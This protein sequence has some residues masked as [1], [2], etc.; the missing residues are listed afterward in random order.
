MT[1]HARFPL[2]TVRARRLALLPLLMLGCALP[3]ML[4]WPQ[5]T[6]AQ[7][8]TA[9]PA[10]V[11]GLAPDRRPRAAPV[12]GASAV[13]AGTKRQRLQGVSQPWP[14]N[15]ERVAEQG[16][17]YSPFFHPGMTGPYDLRAWHAGAA[18]PA[19]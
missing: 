8:V 2:P 9:A 14:G 3:P 10:P 5:P 13:D 4:A 15:V 12:L 16:A 17:W 1:R 18:S 7:G 11:A 19:K 6:Q